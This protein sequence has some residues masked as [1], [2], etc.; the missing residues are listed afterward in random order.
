MFEVKPVVL[1]GRVVRLEPLGR[2]HAAGLERALDDAELFRWFP[3]R[4]NAVDGVAG[5]IKAAH[6]DRD[7]GVSL[8]F[9]TVLQETG[10]AIG[11]TRFGAIDRKNLRAEVGWTFL[12][13]PWQRT[14][15]N[16][17]AKYL[18]LRHAMEVWKL[19]RVE[20]KTHSCNVQSRTALTALGAQEEGTLRKHMVMPDGSARDTMYY[21]ILD[22]EWAAVKARLE[23]RGVGR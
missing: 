4:M 2:E 14:G 15:A 13:R 19:R 9:A 23:A 6:E 21:S 22:I 10:E 3:T 12:L 18:M 20:F 5:W 11:S 1:E 7:R 16:R 17:E 8:P